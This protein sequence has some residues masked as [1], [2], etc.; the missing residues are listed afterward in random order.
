[1]LELT[2]GCGPVPEP[3]G[4][5]GGRGPANPFM[6]GNVRDGSAAVEEG[7][8]AARSSSRARANSCSGPAR[9]PGVGA[10]RSPSSTGIGPVNGP[11]AAGAAGSCGAGRAAGPAFRSSSMMALKPWV[12]AGL[13]GWSSG[14]SAS[15]LSS[16]SHSIDGSSEASRVA[17]PEAWG[18]CSLMR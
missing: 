1:M 5:D 13:T 14:S 16:P 9:A 8:A 18:R 6:S 7:S 2:A 11:G 10:G 17:R 3:P 4:W 15:D 12:T